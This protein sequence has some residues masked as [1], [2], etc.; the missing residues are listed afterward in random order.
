[1]ET[2]HWYRQAAASGHVVAVTNLGALL[3]ARGDV[4]EAKLWRS[5]AAEDQTPPDL[6]SPWSDNE[7]PA[8]I[9]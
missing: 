6:K 7:T 1:L 4:V 9:A 8:V 3:E 5:K 2:A